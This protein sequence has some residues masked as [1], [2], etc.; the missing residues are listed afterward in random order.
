M[1]IKVKDII[2][3]NSVWTPSKDYNTRKPKLSILMPTYGRGKNGFFKRAVKSYIE[4]T[5][6]DTE[7][8][9]VD[10][11]NVDG[12]SEQIDEFMKQDDRISCIRHK[13]NM[14]LPAI[15]SYEA[16]KVAR[17]E[18][19]GFL[20]DDCVLYPSAYERSLKKMENKGAQ[21]SYGRVFLHSDI[22]DK[23]KGTMVYCEEK[24]LDNLEISNYIGNITIIFKKDILKKI[25]YIDPHVSLARVNDWDFITRIKRKFYLIETGVLFAEEYGVTQKSSLGNSYLM[26]LLVI[27]EY[28]KL[29]NREERLL[30]D[31][32]EEINIFSKKENA[33]YNFDS[34]LK[35]I[36][37]FFKNKYW[38][39]FSED[40]KETSFFDDNIV[41]KSAG[42]DILSSSIT[43]I[44]NKNANSLNQ[45][46]FSYISMDKNIA[47]ARAVILVRE[48]N[49][50]SFLLKKLE[51]AKIPT[52]FLWDDDFLALSKENISDINITEANLKKTVKKLKGLIF[53][54]KNFYNTYK[55]ENYSEY[56]YLLNPIY[57][58]KIEKKISLIKNN[59][60]NVAFTGGYWRIKG[61]EKMLIEILNSIAEYTDIV[62]YIPSREEIKDIFYE[63]KRKIKFKFIWYD[64]TFSYDQLISKL[65]NKNI[66]I[67]IH[68]AQFSKNNINKTKN[69]LITASLLGAVL[70]TTDEAP[71][72][73]KDS[74][75]DI[76]PY[77]L[78]SNDKK[79]W[80]EAIKYLLDDKIRIDIV[81]KARHY[82]KKIYSANCLDKFIKDVLKNTPK[83][84]LGLY[85]ERLERLAYF[86]GKSELG[87]F[88]YI[89]GLGEDIIATK[90]INK[91]IKTFFI[92]DKR[93]FS[94]IGIIFGTHCKKI[95]G[96]CDLK[97]YDNKKNQI[98]FNTILLDHIID[99]ELYNIYIDHIKEAMGEKFY[100]SFVFHYKNIKNKISIYE[101]N[102]RH[103]DNRIIR[104]IIRPFRKN[105]IYVELS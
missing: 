64:F 21:A 48:T 105:E 2:K 44:F 36:S 32:Y 49:M 34:E 25:G 16:L 1:N 51:Y 19:I 46:I 35:K 74:K 11:A 103:S 33:S 102:Y 69:A 66:H 15:S 39:N 71:Y 61:F 27:D 54:S 90:K 88:H 31:N 17:G 9:I 70:I 86:S 78:V 95:F 63:N 20:F 75:E 22:N 56:N 59:T 81:E 55:Q 76:M 83:V 60:L 62:L 40:S 92:S 94:T 13:K 37:K 101:R 98:Y 65:G 3:D 23:T 26:N 8:I 52:Y 97:I 12:T 6:E 4:Q 67:L 79:N 57:L 87:N 96:T 38:M 91:K 72:N 47:K 80:V 24:F 42:T 29:S 28:L 85:S 18:Y 82:C 68:P 10:D 5:F 73:I 93:E 58:E 50:S 43:L 30:L 89:A 41:I 45:D 77:L 99:N 84:D 104:N 14:G 7:L 100:I 53:T